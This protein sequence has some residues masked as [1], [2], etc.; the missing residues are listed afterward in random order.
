MGRSQSTPL[1]LARI[2]TRPTSRATQGAGSNYKNPRAEPPDHGLG[3]SRGG[4]STKIHQ[5]VDGH[6]LPLVIAVTAGQ[7]NDA[8]A[9][10]PLLAQLRVARPLGRPRTR[11]D[12]L[13]A[14]KAYSSRAIRTHL[15]ERGIVA[16]IP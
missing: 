1:S 12:R 13:R 2:S 8:P 9:L 11:P 16:V 7:A 10:L 4:L 3:R 6:G 15:R 14:D 5:L